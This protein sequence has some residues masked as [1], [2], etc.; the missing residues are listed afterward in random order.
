MS[1]MV[2]DIFVL[3]QDLFHAMRRLCPHQPE[4]DRARELTVGDFSL[5]VLNI[6]VVEVDLGL[7]SRAELDKHIES[8]GQTLSVSIETLNA[9]VNF[10]SALS[11]Y[12]RLSES[13][14]KELYC[15]VSK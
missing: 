12:A 9:Y 3:E 2:D 8:I 14:A 5:F 13:M 11:K 6:G 10:K 4:I 15:G 1:G 7:T